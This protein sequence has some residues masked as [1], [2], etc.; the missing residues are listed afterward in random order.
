M[1]SQIC[2]VCLLLAQ[3]AREKNMT[4]IGIAFFAGFIFYLIVDSLIKGKL[5]PK[6]GPIRNFL[7]VVFILTIIA[8][9]LLFIYYI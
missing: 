5:V 1:I 2:K 8:L 6:K 9:I 3:N 4:V 7:I